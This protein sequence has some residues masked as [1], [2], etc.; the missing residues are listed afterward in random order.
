MSTDQITPNKT[1]DRLTTCWHALREGYRTANTV[2]HHALGAL[3]K[4]S[5][6]A[7]FI[8]CMLVLALRYLV[9]PNID[10]YKPDV[11][12]M[13][14]RALGNKVTIADIEA[15]WD[16][17]RPRLALH[18]VVIH[19]KFGN[20]A[21]HLPDVSA[22]L[23]WWTVPAGD[24]RL[25][26]LEI[27]RPDMDVRRDAD[28]KLYVAG[29]YIDTG[30]SGNGKGADWVLSQ[31]EI[32]IRDG[33]LHWN[34]YKRAAP[35]LL[36]EN[37]DLVLRN[38]W[39]T[40]RFAL[41][42]TPPAAFAA[43][44]DVRAAFEHPG[45][46][47]RISDPALWKGELYADL[48]DTDLTV[49]KTYLD[50]PVEMQ[51]GKGSVRAW[52][53][54]DHARVANF[55]SDLSLTN[56][57]TRLRPD[58]PMMIL[59]DVSGRVSVREE[60]NPSRADGKPTLGM[61]GHAISLTDFSLRTDDGLFLPRT[62]ISESFTPARRGKP[63][64]TEIKA[65]LLD[66]QTLA[67]FVER[68]PLPVEQ[69]QMLADF[70]PRGILK[71]FSAQWQGTY[72]DIS[73]YSVK[74]QFAG[75]SLNAQ[76]AR[77]ARAKSGKMPAQAAVPAIPGF[78]NLTGQIDANDRGG[79]FSLASSGVKLQLPAYFADPVMPFDR[80][81]MQATWAFQGK[82]QLLL[83][84]QKMDFV[85]ESLS[86]SF[87]GKHMMSL[88]G[89]S[90]KP[91]GTIDV[92]GKLNGLEL[93]NVGRY[94]PLQTPEGLRDWLSGALAGGTVHDLKF[95]LKGDLAQFPF[96]HQAAGDRA[97]GDFSV[98][99][100]IEGGKLNYTPGH[101]GKD[102]KAPFWPLLEDIRGTIAFD[103][104]RMEINAHSAKTA[105]VNLSNVKAVIPDL[106]THD[107]QLAID[108]NAEGALQNFVQFTKDSPVADWIGQFTE[109][110][111]ANGNARLD[112]KLQMPLEHMPDTK[113]KGTLQFAGN[114]VTLRNIIPPLLSA[115]GKLEFHEKGF[116]LNGIKANFLGGPVT[117]TGGTQ[118]DGNI[119]VKADGML[120]AEGVRKNYGVQRSSERISGSTRYSTLIRVRNKQ[121]DITV[122]SNMVGV[123]LDFP[124]PLRKTA[125]ESMPLRFELTGLPSSNSSVA[126]DEMKLSLGS[127]IV[128]RY[129]RQKTADK[130][131]NWR[132]VRGGIGVNVPAPQPDAGVVANVSLK[133]LDVDAWRRAMASVVA[134]DKSKEQQ[135]GP[136]IAPYIEPEVLAARAGELVVMN[137]K[138]DNVVVG[139]SHQKGVWQANID[140]DQASGYLTWNEAQPGQGLGKVTARLA[141]LIIP[142]AAASDVTDLLEGKNTS[143]QIPAVDIVAENFELFGK[144]FGHLELAASDAGGP[145]GREWRVNKLSLVNADAEFKATGKWIL[146]GGENISNLVYTLN[147]G[148]AGRLLDRFGFANVLRGGRGKMEGDVSWKGLPFSLDIPS[149]MGK[150][151]L[152]MASGQ[153]LKVD[154]AAAK[155]LGVLSLQSLPR[156]L[157]LDFRDVF[158]QGFAFDGITATASIMHGVARTDNFKMRGVAAT[159]LIDGSAD[160][161]KEAQNLHVVVI[162]EINV[163]TASVVYG[164]AVNPVIGVGSFLAQL[165]LR[166]P[167]MKAFT[168]EYQ[169]TGPWKDP[170]VTKLL[171]KPAA[172]ASEALN[173]SERSG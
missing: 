120:S 35:E 11:E 49:W 86:G 81:L 93:Q 101:F 63:E 70:A 152:N 107:M 134:S 112:L 164:L 91:N 19:D 69:R 51:Q 96:Q 42:A 68:L 17:L 143:T 139:A 67:S 34:D 123:A 146:R 87:S 141:S 82:D 140:S 138:L 79:S 62:T 122:E 110:T 39:R 57:S 128:A 73:S 29:I 92:S 168:F 23:S 77:P 130:D 12:Q 40:H 160:I 153:F 88:N 50:Y 6:A 113:V 159:V 124:A 20:A 84:V 167:L 48:R 142:E 5:I 76:A 65:R 165:F 9:L 172:P 33:R 166:D 21:L 31:N 117:I 25:H 116:N 27:V 3:L 43:P 136:S 54:F 126:R 98:V 129:E 162:P 26:H 154:P 150:L 95:R 66:L 41:K 144:K 102:G 108:G 147:I 71:D 24:L 97:R 170:V 133:S 100:R 118:R 46:T 2:T 169:I 99:G 28:G 90:G 37:V 155:L 119:V 53:D 14:T 8:F 4:L 121:P 135:D 137:K 132:V 44:L 38:H 13:A 104:T 80:L 36:L 115:N 47:P 156:R 58:L 18:D 157:A 171:R 45:F 60:I 55:T 16:G 158:S 78:D 149:L 151:T 114:N 89:K 106:A 59:A 127:A 145:A 125:G 163:G 7:Y 74:G 10:S 148:D 161:A 111:K 61:N 52:L 15:S 32:V 1:T 103:R 105:G 64:K 85:Q 22:T 83:D 75:L 94:L 173:N 30:K 131:A 56:V 72:P 109:E